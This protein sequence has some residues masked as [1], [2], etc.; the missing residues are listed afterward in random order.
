MTD[1]TVAEMDQSWRMYKLAE[2]L[3]FGL[4]NSQ[5]WFSPQDMARSSLALAKIGY[6]N[7]EV[8]SMWLAH[9]QNRL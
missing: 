9:L 5:A 2:D 8:Q 7:T 4:S 6:K 1:Y 3:K